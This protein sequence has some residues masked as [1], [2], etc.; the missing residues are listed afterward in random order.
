MSLGTGYEKEERAVFGT[1]GALPVSDDDLAQSIAFALKQNREAIQKLAA[2]DDQG[3]P[4]DLVRRSQSR[5]PSAPS[6]KLA[7][8]A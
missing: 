6:L 4:H 3:H 5:P 7:E 1:S 8:R 2:C